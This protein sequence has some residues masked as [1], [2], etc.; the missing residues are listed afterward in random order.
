MTHSKK[1]S[2][3]AKLKKTSH[4]A[5]PNAKKTDS[6]KVPSHKINNHNPPHHKTVETLHPKSQRLLRKPGLLSRYI[7]TDVLTHL[8][9]HTSSKTDGIIGA[10]TLLNTHPDFI[11]LDTRDRGFARHGLMTTLRYMP[12]LDQVLKQKISRNPKPIV[13][14]VLRLALTELFF[15]KTPAHGVVSS[16]LYLLDALGH[17]NAK[18]LAN[19]VLRHVEKPTNPINPQ[20][21]T[22]PWFWDM[23]NTDYDTPTA[24]A[25]ANAH[26]NPPPL[27]ITVK[28]NVQQWAETLGGTILFPDH[29]GFGGTV[30]LTNS[31]DVTQLKGYTTGDWWVQDGGAS[32][33]A[34][35]LGSTLIQKQQNNSKNN[36]T[37]N[38][39]PLNGITIADMCSAPGGKTMQLASAGATVT[40]MDNNANRLQRVRENLSRTDLSAHII[41]DDAITYTAPEPFDGVLVDA[42]CSATGT[43]RRHPELPL[44]KQESDFT[45]LVPLQHAILKNAV[46]ITKSGGYI[47]FATCSLRHAEGEHITDWALKNLP[48]SICPITQHDLGTNT[49]TPNQDGTLRTNPHQNLDGF[50]VAKFLVQ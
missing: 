13:R 21:T 40:A 26:L 27:D 31:G 4:K 32:L 10:D 8:F 28:N 44:L 20:Q 45:D 38:N 22:P 18:G 23:L 49:I 6:T 43:V 47:V 29:N 34:K 5:K 12:L 30:R 48:L 19:A 17:G 1:I 33:P 16:A 35:I 14:H 7:I 39:A 50:Y 41:C 42:P 9:R 46:S 24:D 2:R 36:N 11:T 15:M 25:I 37:E 3:T